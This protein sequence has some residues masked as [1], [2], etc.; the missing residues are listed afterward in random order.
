MRRRQRRL[1]SWWRHEQQSIA[2][3]ATVSHHSHPKVDTA[4]DGLRAQ[5][6]VTSTGEEVEHAS[7]FGLRAQKTPPPGCGRAV[8]LSPRRRGA[9][10]AS[11]APQR[12]ACRSSPCRLWRARQARQWTPPTSASSQLL[13][14]RPEGEGGEDEEEGEGGEE[15]A[16]DVGIHGASGVASLPSPRPL[17]GR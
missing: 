7:H 14:W 15:G 9:T 17:L 12:F 16:A 6:T 13:R 10:A 3:L 2:L 8:S 5:K 4:N 1:R 11:G